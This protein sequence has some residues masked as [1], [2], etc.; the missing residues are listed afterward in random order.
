MKDFE[1]II[2][3]DDYEK[4]SKKELDPCL[5]LYDKEMIYNH[6]QNVENKLFNILNSDFFVFLKTS[7][8]R[9]NLNLKHLYDLNNYINNLISYLLK[10]QNDYKQIVDKIE[11]SDSEISNVDKECH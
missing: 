5:Y 9:K 11:I 2:N 10:L 6:I 3:H 1:F 8:E 4:I 7:L